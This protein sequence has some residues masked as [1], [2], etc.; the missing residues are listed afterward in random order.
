MLQPRLKVQWAER[1]LDTLRQDSAVM[2]RDLYDIV[3]MRERSIAVLS[4]PDIFDLRYIPKK[5]VQEHYALIIGDIVH[6]LR[7][8]LDYWMTAAIREFG[9]TNK[10]GRFSMP[11]GEDV[12]NLK[13]QPAYKSVE[14]AFPES[15]EFIADTIQ[16]YPDGNGGALS[17]ISRLN[18][19]DKHR[20]ILPTVTGAMVNNIY[21]T[22]G[23]NTFS[24]CGIGGNAAHEIRMIRS[25]GAPIT[26]QQDFK[27]SV[28]VTFPKGGAFEDEPAIPVLLNFIEATSQALDSCEDFLRSL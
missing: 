25:Q 21:A 13:T 10:S 26:I 20:F 15:C 22:I 19:T 14:K 3:L 11:F 23:T 28:E 8:A 2:P 5:P 24:N 7:S 17:A 9:S 1:H 27:T 18:N 4:Q 6:N 12:E 16:P